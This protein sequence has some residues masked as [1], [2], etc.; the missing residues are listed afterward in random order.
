MDQEE[1]LITRVGISFVSEAQACASAEDEVPD[2]DFDLTHMA[3]KKAWEDTL[4]KIRVD[5]GTED[6]KVLFYS[7]VR[8]LDDVHTCHEHYI[9]SLSCSYTDTS[10]RLLTRQERIQSGNRQSHT[11]MTFIAFGKTICLRLSL[12][13]ICAFIS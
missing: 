1:P 8:I 11:M 6:D 10:S 7:S 12:A 2:F 5:G 3:A 9:Y 4:S 13:N